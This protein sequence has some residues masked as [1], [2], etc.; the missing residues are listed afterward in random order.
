MFVLVDG[1]YM[2]LSR[3]VKGIKIPLTYEEAKYIVGQEAVRKDTER[4]FG[5]LKI[6]WKFV[7]CPIEILILNDIADLFDTSQHCCG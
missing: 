7:C 2:N 4:A 1:I 3:Y 6:L 5:N